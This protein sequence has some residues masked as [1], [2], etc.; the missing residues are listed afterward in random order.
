M[1]ACGVRV[2]AY[3]CKGTKSLG[4]RG[5]GCVGVAFFSLTMLGSGVGRNWRER[6]PG[7]RA[8]VDTGTGVVR[9]DDRGGVWPGNW[10]PWGGGVR[11]GPLTLEAWWGSRQVSLAPS[12]LPSQ[13]SYKGKRQKKHVPM[14]RDTQPGGQVQHTLPTPRPLA[15]SLAPAPPATNRGK[16]TQPGRVASSSLHRCNGP[17]ARPLPLPSPAHRSSVSPLRG[18]RPGRRANYD[19]GYLR[20]R[21]LRQIAWVAM[22]SRRDEKCYPRHVLVL[23]PNAPPPH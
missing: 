15:P 9:R 23:S 7:S 8:V 6:E 16:Q 5:G 10:G 2:R 22:G 11:C 18:S 13:A 3:V 21:V 12:V 4:N 17:G 19:R 20:W 1:G 14:M